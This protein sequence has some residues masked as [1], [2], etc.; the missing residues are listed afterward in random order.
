MLTLMIAV[1]LQEAANKAGRITGGAD[2][3]QGIT[4]APVLGLFRFD[5]FGRTAYL[6]CLAVLFL[7][8]LAVR[9]H[10]PFAVRPLADRHSRERRPHARDRLAGA[11]R[12]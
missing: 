5:M 9:A 11:A 8:W 10:R 12:G 4:I 1:M 6:Y 7:G 3:L 2:G